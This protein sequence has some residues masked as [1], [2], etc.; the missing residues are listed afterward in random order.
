MFKRLWRRYVRLLFVG[1]TALALLGAG[2]A[3]AGDKD[4]LQL[5]KQ[6]LELQK[7]QN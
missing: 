4:D 6:Q 3:H 5:L 1:G 7:K 2:T